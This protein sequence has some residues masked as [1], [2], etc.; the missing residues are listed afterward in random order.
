MRVLFFLFFSQIIHANTGQP[1]MIGRS[2][3][4]PVAHSVNIH[5]SQKGIVSVKDMNTHIVIT[6]KKIGDVTI[7][8]GKKKYN[9]SVI[10]KK[11]FETYEQLLPLLQ[12]K[13]GLKLKIIDHTPTIQGTLYRLSD[14]AELGKRLQTPSY[15]FHAQI[16][17]PLIQQARSLILGKF[18]E[19]NTPMVT[20]KFEPTPKVFVSKANSNIKKIARQYGIP[21][22]T[23]S[24]LVE[25]E[26][27]VEVNIFVA[28]VKKKEF[29]RYGIKWPSSYSANI[30]PDLN[31]NSLNL[32]LNALDEKG[33]AK[34][35]ASPKLV[36]KSGSSAE[37]LAG[38]EIPIKVSG[39]TSNR[40]EWKTYGIKL[41]I[42]PKASWSGKMSIEVSTEVSNIDSSQT[43]DGVPGLLTNRMKSH[44]DMLQ[45]QTIVLSGL[46]Q[47]DVG[48]SSEGLPLLS[49]IP[50]LGALFS[51]KDYRNNKTELVFFV[52]PRV[53]DIE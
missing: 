40:V 11:E 15:F 3:Q 38:G 7:Q 42:K 23:V 48:R 12:D 46:I 39:Y 5:I 6:G 51:S 41:N 35:L 33:D 45:P 37:F 34:L 49:K 16:D 53:I 4:L 27:M 32:T 20:L 2:I 24:G 14:W 28:E 8:V 26:P 31:L 22:Q 9:I 47:N 43:V 36:C 1:L 21:I 25:I 13:M 29:L 18:K 52:T 44:F 19:L 50:I 10:G 17:P 30:S